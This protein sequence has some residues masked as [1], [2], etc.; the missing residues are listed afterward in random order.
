M[1]TSETKFLGPRRVLQEGSLRKAKS[2]RKLYAYLCN[3]LL[4]LFVPGRAAG[5]LAKSASYTSLS[6]S[7]S[8][9][10][11]SSSPS[12]AASEGGQ[13]GNHGWTLYH[14]PIP[15]ERIKIKPDAN[16]D[17]KFTIVVASPVPPSSGAQFSQ[18][19]L[20]LQSQQT[21]Q[22]GPLQSMIH[23]KAGSSRE[24]KAWLGAVQK[25]IEVL[26]KAPRD[27]GMR[28]SI[29]PS[30]AETIGTMT[31][32]VNEAVIP[33]RE[34]A[35][36]KS[37][38]CTISLGD[39]LFTTRPSSTE[40]PFSGAFSILWR[41]STIFA[42]TDMSHVLDVKLMSTCPFS[43]D[44]FMGSAQVPFHTV[45]PYG[46]R[47]TEVLTSVGKDTQIKFHMSYKAL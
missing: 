6:L 44:V 17:T 39:Q 19:P 46:E 15:L 42:I 7:A 22:G 4:L 5:A 12:A 11:L 28:T 20:H 13:N 47:G 8:S 24:R 30:L 34:F 40:H 23:V 35:K 1:L 33:S 14:A 3:D 25:A 37:F 38:V 26:A 21:S 2:G 45:I 29:R 10:S 18:I 41:E 9:P 16:D 43:P 27:Y 32:R 31:I 36:S